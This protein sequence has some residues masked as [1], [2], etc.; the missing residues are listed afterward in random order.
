M[1]TSRIY[2]Q[3]TTN[4]IRLE[5]VFVSLWDF[6]AAESDELAL[7]RGDLVYVSS[8]AASEEW[9]YGEK[10]DPHASKKIGLAGF[11]PKCYSTTAFETINS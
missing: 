11:F 10:L 3:P 4:G 2:D 8:P 7:T 5:K 1:D 9:W 6:V